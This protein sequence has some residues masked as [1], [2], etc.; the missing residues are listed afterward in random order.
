MDPE[1]IAHY[2]DRY[3]ESA[4]LDGSAFDRVEALRTKEILLRHLPAPPAVVLDVGGGPGVY[5]SWL[6]GLGY[7]VHLVDPVERHV[8]GAMTREPPPLS[9]RVGDARSLDFDDGSADAVLLLGPLYHL[10]EKGDRFVAL[11]E[12]RRVLRQGGPV[13]VA[14]ISRFASAFDGLLDGLDEDAGFRRIVEQDLETGIHR[15]PTD[16]PRFFTTSYW[17]LPSGLAAEVEEA[18]FED[19][20]VLAVEGVAWVAPDLE[21]RLADPG[22]REYLLGL[23]RRLE[24][25][26]GIMGA[27]PH[28]LAVGRK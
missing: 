17:H 21:A 28:M 23:I 2:A 6:S 27:S 10:P 14:G 13:F 22:R 26:P 20:E 15:N 24:R 9:A 16:N 8:E 12:A 18:G 11:G 4:R 7:E 25:E 3:D 5:A 19:V 1:I